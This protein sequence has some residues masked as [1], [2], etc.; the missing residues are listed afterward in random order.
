MSVLLNGSSQFL[1]V[2]TPKAAYPYSVSFWFKTADVDQG[3]G[4]A[5]L[6]SNDYG[7]SSTPHQNLSLLAGTRTN[8]EVSASTY[9]TTWAT[10]YCVSPYPQNDTW[11]HV[12]I[13]F[14]DA[15]NRHVL[16]DGASRSAM[17]G[18][19]NATS[20]NYFSVGA[21]YRSSPSVFYGGRIAEVAFY[22]VALSD[23]EAA[24]LAGGTN[25]QDVQAANLLNY[26]TLASGNG[27]AVGGSALTEHNSP[28][29][30]AG[31]HPSID[32]P[33]S[34]SSSSASSSPSSSSSASSSSSS[35]SSS[36]ASSSSSSYSSSSTSS[37]SSSLGPL[38]FPALSKGVD[39]AITEDVADTGELVSDPN[40]GRRLLAED[41]YKA[42]HRLRLTISYMSAADRVTL[43][44]FYLHT[45]VGGV[46]VW[47][48]RHPKSDQL[49]LLR[50]DPRRPPVYSR[51]PRQPDKH[52]A[53][54][55]VVEALADGYLTG[56]YT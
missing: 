48:W 8:N 24:Q 34:S 36:S 50:F 21:R 2:A 3:G 7:S 28:T 33:S 55:T 44:R 25:P 40:R 38:Q 15:S 22:G 9:A 29:Y 39:V 35:F 49:W 31:D 13:V 10:A 4:N 53:E 27:S 6:V 19:Q 12:T 52:R 11:H 18:T 41:A 5:V 45:T 37:S 54:L 17:P 51:Q 30:S 42:A 14:P 47:E 46:C 1:D 26:W 16:L 43:A 23:A 20:V 32:A 56:I